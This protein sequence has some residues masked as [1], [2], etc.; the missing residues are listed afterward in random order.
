MRTLIILFVFSACETTDVTPKT[1]TGQNSDD[2]GNPVVDTDPPDPQDAD[3]DGYTDDCDDNNPDVFPG[4]AEVCDGLDNDC[5]GQIDDGALDATAWYLDDDGDGYG[6]PAAETA[7]CEEPLDHVSNADDCDDT[8]ARFNP[9]A[10][11]ADCED[12]LDYNCDGS[13]GY[14]DADS[15]GWA[16]CIECDDSDAAVNPDGTEICNGVDDDCNGLSDDEDPL[17]TGATTWYGDS[18]GDGYGGQQYEAQ[19][20]V[21]PAGFVDNVDDCNDLDPLTFPSAAEICDEADNDCDTIV[22]EGVG[23]TWYADADGDGYGDSL[24]TVDS[25]DMPAGYSANGD[26]CDDNS[27]ATSPAAYEICDGIDNN[28]DGATDDASAL[29][30]ST[31]YA[32]TDGDGYGDSGSTSDACSAPSGFVADGTDCDDNSAARHPAADEVCDGADNDCDGSTDEAS[33]TDATTWYVDLDA[34]GYGSPATS[35]TACTAP[36]GYVADATDCDDLDPA[37]NPGGTE[38]CDSADADEDCDGAADDADPEGASGKT[39]GYPDGDSDGYGDASSAGASYCDPP[40]SVV[41]DNTDC[42]DGTA[43]TYPGASE[44]CDG[45]DSDC[46]SSLDDPGEDNCHT[47]AACIDPGSGYACTCGSGYEGDGT[48]SCDLDNFPGSVLLDATQ[49]AQLNT[50]ASSVGQSWTL[51]YR[52]STDGGD[53]STF[54]SQCDGYSTTYSVAQLDTNVLMGGY[55]A[56]SWSHCSCYTGNSASFL[57]SLT[58]GYKI[59]HGT[60]QHSSSHYQYNRNTYGPT[61]GGGHDWHVP[62]DLSVSYTNLGYSS[63]CQV[64]SYGGGSCNSDFN[65]STSSATITDLEV[66]GR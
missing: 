57:F 6:D 10:I 7:S 26:D 19:A 17:L 24:S 40:G 66:W 15:D 30:T 56:S 43:T 60:G 49:K 2:T 35:Q 18:D 12:P 42:D 4:N 46:D 50:W 29:N 63:G 39:V 58:Q 8:D 27:A 9:S 55:T 61:F 44:T 37:S 33:A 62:N 23:S 45:V 41:S 32:D 5:N 11:E 13:V 1:E 59:P 51:C 47:L 52:K 53:S 38:V 48:S 34:D 31:W 16:A 3:G 64:G 14:A 21:V 65:G 36:L 20:C 28:C 22:D 25:C 54:H